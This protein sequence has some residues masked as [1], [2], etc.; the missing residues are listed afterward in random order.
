MSWYKTGS[1]NVTNG[2]TTVT[3]VGTAWIANVAAGEGIKIA[4]DKIYEIA[5]VNSDTQLTLGS[6]YLGGTGV[7]SYTVVPTQGYL[8]D[9][10]AQAA[11]LVQQYSTAQAS[12]TGKAPIANPTFTGVALSSNSR[13]SPGFAQAQFQ[14]YSPANAGYDFA[15]I[16]FHVQ[17]ASSAPQFGYNVTLG[18]F[19]QFNLNGDIGGLTWNPDA[20]MTGL[21]KANA[22]HLSAAVAGVDYVTP[23]STVGLKVTGMAGAINTLTTSSVVL[24]ASFTAT[25]I[26]QF[27]A[28][29][30]ANNKLHEFY[31]SGGKVQGRFLND[32]YTTASNW[33]AVTGGQESG[34]SAIDFFAPVGVPIAPTTKWQIDLSAGNTTAPNYITMAAAATLQL[35]SGSGLVIISDSGSTNSCNV[36]TASGGAVTPV[37]IVSTYFSNV[38]DTVGKINLYWDG[39]AFRYIIQNNAAAARTLTICTIQ[40]RTGV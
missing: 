16:A 4:D 21:V 23:V 32:T 14:A 22:G 33:V 6:P 2:S 20:P 28:S 38:K 19:G 1:I 9:L 36:F 3:G 35:A 12:I 37:S 27:D 39:A 34:V 18:K 15:S 17:D 8:R 11:S 31:F 40:T 30:T 10:A 5:S 26:S 13:S 24:S 25:A 29:R 7:T